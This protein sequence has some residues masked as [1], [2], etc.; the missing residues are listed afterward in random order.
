MH[1]VYICTSKTITVSWRATPVGQ[2][3]PA[4]CGAARAV[5]HAALEGRRMA[6]GMRRRHEERLQIQQTQLS[7]KYHAEKAANPLNTMG[8]FFTFEARCKLF[9]ACFYLRGWNR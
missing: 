6:R 8:S 2:R 3:L 4:R 9:I 5:E 7:T 1:D